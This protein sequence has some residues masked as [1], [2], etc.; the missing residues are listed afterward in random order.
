MKNNN[1][2][3]ESKRLYDNELYYFA[4]SYKIFIDTCSLMHSEFSVF[5]M[6]MKSKMKTAKN[7]FIILN[8]VMDEIEN[9]Q[10]SKNEITPNEVHDYSVDKPDLKE[11][12]PG[13]FIYCN[14]Q[15]FEQYKK[16]I[17]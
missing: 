6:N 11:I 5:Y 9:H 7:K 15:E 12:N 16:E 4:K 8:K 17:K 10:N 1:I 2:A 13:H 14:N 3:S